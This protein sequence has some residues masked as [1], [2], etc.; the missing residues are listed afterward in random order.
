MKA[1]IPKNGKKFKILGSWPMDYK[2]GN[3]F[4]P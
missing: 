2:L 1:F 3:T 4:P